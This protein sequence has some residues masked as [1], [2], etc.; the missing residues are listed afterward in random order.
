MLAH[1]EL[2]FINPALTYKLVLSVQ[3]FKKDRT[4]TKETWSIVKM[5][6]LKPHLRAKYLMSSAIVPNAKGRDPLEK[7]KY[8]AVLYEFANDSAEFDLTSIMDSA[9]YVKILNLIE[10]SIRE[11]KDRIKKTA[12]IVT[13]IEKL[14]SIPDSSKYSSVLPVVSKR[15]AIEEGSAGSTNKHIDSN[16]ATAKALA[17]A[18]V[19]SNIADYTTL[20]NA[21][22]KDLL[23]TILPFLFTSV[24][25]RK[26]GIVRRVTLRSQ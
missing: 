1:R 16:I 5:M 3:M 26:P 12:P 24:I 25:A 18:Y 14:D 22:Y 19:N 6:S 2:K 7:D 4:P 17:K 10:G 8:L 9:M 13:V 20:Y 21:V 15:I 11:S 23:N